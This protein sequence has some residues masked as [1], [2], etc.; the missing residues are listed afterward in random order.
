MPIEPPPNAVAAAEAIQKILAWVEPT[1]EDSHYLV[2]AGDVNEKTER[3]N[4][5]EGAKRFFD[6]MAR[7]ISSPCN[8][9]RS[10]SAAFATNT[11]LPP[12]E[13]CT[14]A[15]PDSSSKFWRM[16][17]LGGYLIVTNS[18]IDMRN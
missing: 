4:M 6:D 14:F 15:D 18:E 8:S 9:N 7:A 2:A 13:S 10:D 1:E 5:V 16:C 11:K 3:E 12:V 17:R